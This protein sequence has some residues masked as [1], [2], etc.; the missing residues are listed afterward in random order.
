[1]KKVLFIG[2]GINDCGAVTAIMRNIL[3]FSKTD[4][5]INETLY[6]DKSAQIKTLNGTAYE[7]KTPFNGLSHVYYRI[8]RKSSLLLK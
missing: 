7:I 6:C 4:F 3:D 8:L 5:V 2:S 1:M